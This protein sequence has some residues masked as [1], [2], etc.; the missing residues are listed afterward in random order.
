MVFPSVIHVVPPTICLSLA[1]YLSYW[2]KEKKNLRIFIL[3]LLVLTL[4]GIVQVLKQ[5]QANGVDM[6]RM[7]RFGIALWGFIVPLSYHSLTAILGREGKRNRIILLGL[8][9][10]GLVIF[11][12]SLNGYSV[13]KGYYCRFWGWE[14]LLDPFDWFS[15]LFFLFLVSGIP[16]FIITLR[17]VQR[18]TSN[19]SVQKLTQA[20][21]VYYLCGSVFSVIP[22]VFL[23]CFKVP[24]ELF[25]DFFEA[26]VMVLI[27]QSI[28]K[29]QPE[30]MSTS[31]FFSNLTGIFP[32]EMLLI[33]SNGTILST[34][35]D[36][37]LITGYERKNLEG[38]PFRKLFNDFENVE[39][40][41]KKIH[42]NRNYSASFETDCRVEDG[43]T[44]RVRISITGLINSF[45]DLF[46]YLCIF[47]GIEKNEDILMHLQTIFKLSN[48]EK[49]IIALLIKGCTNQGISDQLFISLNTI[50]THTRN[51]YQKT[52][53]A[54]RSE[55][56]NLV[57]KMGENPLRIN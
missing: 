48:R 52:G 21:L 25:L 8:Y 35:K 26:F 45:N 11:T 5:N 55:L 12:L 16:A 36:R 9:F 1:L 2:G 24:I 46:G 23:S 51:I 28:H 34:N 39:K 37:F 20:I 22:Y 13:Y 47:V 56:K 19:Y 15:W 50:K 32:A 33:S 41:L 54:N 38:E 14:G 18:Q 53:T 49:A 57:E 31:F 42:T 40:E 17:Q 43:R 6:D 7:A 4:Y 44:V 30:N 10:F 27:V 3:F 29:F